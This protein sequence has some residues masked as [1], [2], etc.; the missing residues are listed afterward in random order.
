MS[1]LELV[2]I[3]V[4]RWGKKEEEPSDFSQK[5]QVPI[6]ENKSS[7]FTKEGGLFRKDD[8]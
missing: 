1:G 4:I 3:T 6:S 8:L 7:S 5:K 2:S